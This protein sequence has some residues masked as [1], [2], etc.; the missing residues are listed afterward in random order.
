MVFSKKQK[1]DKTN[2]QTSKKTIIETKK[3][4]S[5]RENNL[6]CSTEKNVRRSKNKDTG[7]KQNIKGYQT[8]IN[9]TESSHRKTEPDRENS[10]FTY[11]KNNSNAGRGREVLKKLAAI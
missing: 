4:T 8:K 6:Q 1:V 11:S 9:K 3:K 10:Y 5:I 7:N 2:N